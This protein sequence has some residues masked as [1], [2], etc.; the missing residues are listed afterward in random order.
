MEAPA[1]GRFDREGTVDGEF[2]APHLSLAGEIIELP[3][4]DRRYRTGWKAKPARD[5]RLGDLTAVARDGDSTTPGRI[6]GVH[7]AD[8]DRGQELDGDRCRHGRAGDLELELPTAGEDLDLGPAIDGPGQQPQKDCR[9][10]PDRR[11]PPW[12]QFNSRAHSDSAADKY[13]PP[14]SAEGRGERSRGEVVE[15]PEFRLIRNMRFSDSVHL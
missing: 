12:R 10:Y 1:E 3:I 9:D 4:A 8:L 11:F 6:D 14:G 2:A 15:H 5:A 7:R 13:M